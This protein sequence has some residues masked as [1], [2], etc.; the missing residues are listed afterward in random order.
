MNGDWIQ[1]YTGNQFWPLDPKPEHIFIEDIAHALSNI[2]RFTG[3]C[4][5]FYSVAEHSII[6]SN[7]VPGGFALW[8]LLHDA[9][10]AYIGDMSRPLKSMLPQ[11]KKIESRIMEA[12]IEKF[13]LEPINEPQIVKDIDSGILATESFAIMKRHPQVWTLPYPPIE[14]EFSLYP[15]NEAE[16]WFLGCY[17]QIM[18]NP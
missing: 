9:A 10:E 7:H 15:P 8:G 2:C 5:Y 11:F 6:V 18:R 4:D 1:T 12:V 3:H 14:H 16:L 13:H 17:N